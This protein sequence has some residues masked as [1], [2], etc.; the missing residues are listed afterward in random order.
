MTAQRTGLVVGLVVVVA[1]LLLLSIPGAPQAGHPNEDGEL[2]I[3]LAIR[4]FEPDHL[5]LPTERPLTLTFVNHSDVGHTF[6]FGR[7]TVEEADHPA[8]PDVDMLE[9]VSVQTDPA[10]ALV[11][12]TEDHPYTGF[13]LET[14]ETVILRF[15]IP[16]DRAGEWELGCF[17]AR[18]CYY[19]TGFRAGVTVE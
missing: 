16:E 8:G 13:Y 7:D 19:E 9:G 14:D 11:R 1:A 18:G 3:E 2:A 17:T 6:A 4:D 15:T 12:P 5:Y 10:D